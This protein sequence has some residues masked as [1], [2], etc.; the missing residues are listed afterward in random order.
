MAVAST[1]Q[2]G[3]SRCPGHPPTPHPPPMEITTFVT[4]ARN[5]S[6]WLVYS[7]LFLLMQLKPFT[8]SRKARQIQSNR[9]RAPRAE[10]DADPET[11]ACE[12]PEEDSPGRAH[13]RLAAFPSSH[14][15]RCHWDLQSFSDA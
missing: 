6:M 10:G 8:A 3:V 4:V 13:S 11:P 15:R 1:W 2:D 12:G 9:L 14:I 5:E 7:T